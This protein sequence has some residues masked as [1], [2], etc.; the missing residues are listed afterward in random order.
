MKK[1]E[2]QPRSKPVVNRKGEPLVIDA[3]RSPED[4]RDFA[5][6][7]SVIASLLFEILKCWDDAEELFMKHRKEITPGIQIEGEFLTNLI[8]VAVQE[9]K[10]QG[11]GVEEFLALD[12]GSGTGWSTE[13]IALIIDRLGV[14]ARIHGLDI[15]SLMIAAAESQNPYPVLDQD[16]DQP[17]SISYIQAS[18]AD[19]ISKLFL[20]HK[21]IDDAGQVH[22][23]I[24]NRALNNMQEL[25]TTLNQ[26]HALLAEGG[27]AILSVSTDARDNRYAGEGH[28]YGAYW[29]YMLV[30]EDDNGEPI[31][32]P[33]IQFYWSEEIIKQFLIDAG[34]DEAKITPLYPKIITDDLKTYI[35]KNK[36]EFKAKFPKNWKKMLTE[37]W[38]KYNDKTGQPSVVFFYVQK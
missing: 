33:I 38:E 30:G 19:A 5:R 36:A 6:E 12:L 21:V 7:L 24:S 15:S 27:I 13:L 3:D 11:I 25:Q 37:T 32:V 14:K 18:A 23:I 2:E 28:P 4:I 34:F 22:L 26:I 17:L 8:M 16:L 1:K 29:E 35:K 20:N 9:L 10:K 31:F